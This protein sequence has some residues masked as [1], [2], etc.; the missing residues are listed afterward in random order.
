MTHNFLELKNGIRIIHKPTKSE[1]AHCGFI[2]K[3]G[4]RDENLDQSGITHFIEH[5]IFKGTKNRKAYHILNRIDNV[6]GE[7]NA[8]TTKENTSI[9]ASF[10]KEYLER[11]IEL[12]TDILFNST[13][14]E[15]ELNKEKDVIIDEINSYLDSPYEQ[16]YDDFEELIFKDHPLGMN[17]LGSVDSVKK[18]DRKK[19][20]DFIKTNYRTDQ[21]VLSV[22]GDFP[23]EKLEKLSKKYLTDIP[24]KTSSKARISFGKYTPIQKEIKKDVYQTHCIIGNTAYGTHHKHKKSFV[25]LNNILGGPAMNSRLNFGIREKYGFTYNIESSYTS[26]SDIGLFYIYLGTD[27]KHLDKSI[28][29]VHRELKNLRD[30]KL[31][32]TQLQ[33]A[34]KQIIGQITLSEENNCNVMLGMGKS[35]MLYN[36]VDSLEETFNKINAITPEELHIVANEVF[37]KEQLS[38]LIFTPKD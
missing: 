20:L 8:F 11:A 22:V 38:S 33:K 10:T 3:T 17:I 18:I 12:L 15:K 5:A 2:I 29:L 9:Y 24:E 35:L 28:K 34:K 31:S 37:N 19:I 25:L 13:Y 23:F 27:I 16:I 14:P 36:K 1:V 7:I 21:I 4:S 6:G 30:K 32:S 26:F